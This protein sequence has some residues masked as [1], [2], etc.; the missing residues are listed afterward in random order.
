[1]AEEPASTVTLPDPEEAKVE[2]QP[3]RS[4]MRLKGLPPSEAMLSRKQF[5]AN[6]V[7]LTDSTK[8]QAEIQQ[9]QQALLD[10]LSAGAANT[11]EVA[12]AGAST[13]A[14]GATSS[15]SGA[16]EAQLLR[17]LEGLVPPSALRAGVDP[18]E[19]S[20]VKRKVKPVQDSLSIVTDAIAKLREGLE[21]RQSMSSQLSEKDAREQG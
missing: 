18:S 5:R 9:S 7:D 15:S 10:S 11:G 20:P 17:G 4:V 2:E 6:S 13:E 16:A 19:P 1:V 12:M 8:Q 21:T 3:G 14:T